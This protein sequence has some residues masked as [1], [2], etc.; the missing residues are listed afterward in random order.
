[1]DGYL[2]SGYLPPI[3]I[4]LIYFKILSMKKIYL[5]L[6][7]ILFIGCEKEETILPQSQDNLILQFQGQFNLAKYEDSFVRDNLKIRWNDFNKIEEKLETFD[8]STNLS[9][10]LKNTK[11]SIFTKYRLLGYRNNDELEFEMVKFI[12]SENLDAI[13]FRNF[14]SL[15]FSGTIIFRD[16]NGKPT[17]TEVYEDG[18]KSKK[19]K[20]F[21]NN[22]DS[23]YVPENWN[24]PGT[25]RLI[26]T[27]SVIDYYFNSGPGGSF[28]YSHS[29][30][31]STRSEYV[32]VSGSTS[33]SSTN[34]YHNHYDYPHGPAVGSNNHP[35]EIFN[36]EEIPAHIFNELE[37]RTDCVYNKMVDNNNNINWILQNFNDGDKP[38]EFDLKLQMSST[39]GNLTNAST[40]KSG[41]T[42]YIKINSN[43]IPYRTSLSIA[44]TIIHEGIHA[45]LR[46]FASRN[47]SN[48]ISFPGVYNYFREYGKN[49][50]HQQ[51][52]DYYRKT[53]AEGLQQ[54][55]NNQNS[56]EFYMDLAWEGLAGELTNLNDPNGD[57][58]FTTQAWNNLSLSEQNRIINTV[59]NEKENGSKSCE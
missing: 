51:M 41:N 50:D 1:M 35:V 43:R 7:L 8:F 39:L 56:P 21:I 9:S 25:Y 54:Y 57:S 26:F 33:N 44:R 6:T 4:L 47:G 2:V 13:T 12:S 17:K 10:T 58:T 42:F 27:R 23:K 24:S 32:Y 11:D 29:G 28:E 18:I 53:I 14:Q 46:E 48:A 30:F 36:E 49:W 31:G 3:P 34:P 52:A 20:N 19:F 5:L 55:D 40:V 45:R 59:R 37:G 38:S 15:G 16:L 22:N